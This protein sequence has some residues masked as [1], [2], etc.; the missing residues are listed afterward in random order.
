MNPKVCCPKFMNAGA[1]AWLQET[2]K[3]KKSLLWGFS[4]ENGSPS[5]SGRLKILPKNYFL[6]KHKQNSV[7]QKMVVALF[8]FASLYKRSRK[9]TSFRTKDYPLKRQFTCVTLLRHKC[10]KKTSFSGSS[11]VRNA[12]PSSAGGQNLLPKK[13]VRLGNGFRNGHGL[14]NIFLS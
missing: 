9:S 8:F 6:R 14:R 13:K 3:L 12:S 4:V 11:S 2:S 7:M 10:L 5:S 1:S